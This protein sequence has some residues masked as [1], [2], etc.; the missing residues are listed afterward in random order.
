MGLSSTVREEDL[1]GE[2]SEF[3]VGSSLGMAETLSIKGGA[4]EDGLLPANTEF[5]CFA[6]C[7]LVRGDIR[8]ADKRQNMFWGGGKNKPSL[9]GHKK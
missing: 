8:V 5:Q 7:W 3:M 6:N 2:D 1:V 9:N 4:T